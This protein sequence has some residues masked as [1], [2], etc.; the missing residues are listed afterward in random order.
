MSTKSSP[1]F[2]GSRSILLDTDD[3]VF[4]STILI[5]IDIFQIRN[6]D[7]WMSSYG[8]L[9]LMLF[10]VLWVP[11]GFP[12][13]RIKIKTEKSEKNVNSASVRSCPILTATGVKLSISWTVGNAKLLCEHLL[14][15]GRSVRKHVKGHPIWITFKL[16][17]KPV[18]MHVSWMMVSH[19]KIM[20]TWGEG[21][22]FMDPQGVSWSNREK[23]WFICRFCCASTSKWP[24]NTTGWWGW[25]VFLK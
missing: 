1:F 12:C 24:K 25:L 20:T 4:V 17:S 9:K 3:A 23:L 2:S 21:P 6:S 11:P 8:H 5:F 7:N 18:L 16:F 13:W 15:M 19:H 22:S 14:H 10:R